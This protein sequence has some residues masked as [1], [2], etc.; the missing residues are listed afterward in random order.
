MKGEVV[1]EIIENPP[2]GKSLEQSLLDI[3]ES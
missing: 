2:M 3:I 1:G